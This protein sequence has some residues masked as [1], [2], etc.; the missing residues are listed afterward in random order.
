VI[1]SRLR[2]LLSGPLLGH[3]SREPDTGQLPDNPVEQAFAR[4]AW[5]GARIAFFWIAAAFALYVS[6]LLPPRLPIPELEARFG[7][8]VGPFLAQTGAQPGWAWLAQLG[9][10]DHLSLAGLVFTTG[11]VM[12]AFLATLA[13]LL[14]QRDWLYVGL[15]AFQ[16]LIFV[17]AAL[18]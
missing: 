17:W 15:V 10:G 18:S 4:W 3:S 14:R 12:L 16:V 9:Y 11:A 2:R 7:L 6:G 13:P 5:A 1:L 8:P